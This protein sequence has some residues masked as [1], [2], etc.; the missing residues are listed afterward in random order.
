MKKIKLTKGKFVIVDDEDFERLNQFQWFYNMYAKRNKKMAESII[1]WRMH[2]DIIGR[3]KKGFVVD[4]INGDRLDNRKENLRI[5]T[6]SENQQ[7]RKVHRNGKLA[8]VMINR[9]KGKTYYYAHK[10]IKGKSVILGKGKTPEEAHQIFLDS[11]RI[12]KT[13]L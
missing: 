4:H 8:G 3:P 13:N 6:Q 7:N 5:C 10:T 2:W 11:F 9:S 1:D 12:T